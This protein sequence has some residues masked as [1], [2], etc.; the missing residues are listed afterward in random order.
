MADKENNQELKI[1][2]ETFLSMQFD[3]IKTSIT[4][5]TDEIKDLVSNKADKVDL[6]RVKD[7]QKAE[8]RLVKD[9]QKKLVICY[10]IAYGALAATQAIL[11]LFKDKIF[12]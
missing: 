1:S 12:G 5:L 6:Q 2:L 9:T 4:T 3:D 8:L 11:I 10:S 7:T